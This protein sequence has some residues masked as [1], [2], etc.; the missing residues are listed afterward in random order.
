MVAGG[1]DEQSKVVVNNK[2]VFTDGK[3]K[4]NIQREGGG[5][6][7]GQMSKAIQKQ[8]VEVDRL[9]RGGEYTPRRGLVG[10]VGQM[11]KTRG[12]NK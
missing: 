5:W 8:L 6:G 2:L 4:G 10:W 11:S 12:G 1:S 9:Q 7:V 3:E